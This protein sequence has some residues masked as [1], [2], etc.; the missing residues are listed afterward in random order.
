LPEDKKIRVPV[1]L[2]PTA[3]GKSDV[4]LAVC[5]QM[6]LE[7]VSCDSRQIYRHMNIGTAKPTGEDTVLVKHWMID[8]IDPDQGYSAFRYAADSAEIIRKRAAVEKRVLLCGGTGLYFKCLSEGMGPQVA[9]DKDLREHYRTLAIRHGNEIVFKELCRIDPVTASASHASNLTRNIRGL[10]V[11]HITGIPLSELKKR[12][13]GP[14]DFVF[15]VMILTLPREELYGRINAR[16]D[17][18][19]KNG[20]W[21]EFKSLRKRGY[22]S[23]SPGLLCVGYRE[24]FAVEEN[25]TTLAQAIE[26]IK[27][28]TRNYAKRQ[29][30]WFKHQVKGIEV[31][32]GELSGDVL[33]S[34]IERFLSHA[35]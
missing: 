34:K 20:L 4:C 28:N 13:S 9:E 30:T 3:A 26:K 17:A 2:G 10:E 27:Q 16:V 15:S 31:A 35:D 33:A 6:G 1:L 11:F 19:I 12:T 25:K 21:E 23:K 22:D 8:I 32:A 24:L 5:K 14:D 18:M 29:I 7:I